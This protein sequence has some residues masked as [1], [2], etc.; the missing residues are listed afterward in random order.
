M[1][2]TKIYFGTGGGASS[3]VFHTA[4]MGKSWTATATPIAAGI[5][6]AGIFSVARSGDTVV[7]VGGDYRQTTLATS[8]AAYSTDRGATWQL[9]ADQPGGYR[10]AVVGSEAR[11]FTAAGPNG[12]DLS[13]DA[14]AHWMHGGSANVNALTV[15]DDGTIWGAGANGTITMLSTPVGFY[16][17][18]TLSD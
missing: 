15:L 5:A 14:G 18:P 1:A 10:S 13:Y 3:R 17:L 9:A 12:V 11:F 8:A 16:P 4:D 2:I 7:V 6:S